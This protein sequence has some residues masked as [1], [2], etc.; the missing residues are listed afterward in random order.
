MSTAT[1]SLKRTRQCAKCPWRVG[2]DPHSIPN[3]YDAEKHRA[4]TVTIA[5]PADLSSLQSNALHSMACHEAHDTH[6][7]GWLMNQLGRGNNLAL[8]LRALSCDNLGQVKLIGPQHECF[9]DTLPKS[10]TVQNK[11]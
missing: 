11:R 6:C 8:R 2:V 5:T 3:G 9:E 1:W 7:I 4:L 10:C